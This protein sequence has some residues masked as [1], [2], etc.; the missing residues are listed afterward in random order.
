[1]RNS[2]SKRRKL[3]NFV[4]LC[5]TLVF[6]RYCIKSD[7]V[8]LERTRKCLPTP[9]P[10]DVVYTWV[11]G[12]DPDF[13]NQLKKQDKSHSNTAEDTSESRFQD[14]N[15]LL[16]SLR[17]IEQYAPWIRRVYIVTNGQIPN[18]INLTSVTMV[19]HK[20][21]FTEPSHLPNFNSLAI[22]T[23]LHEIPGLSENFIYFND[24]LSL[25]SPTCPEDFWMPETGYKSKFKLVSILA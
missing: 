9:F 13:I 6:F 11:N 23:H 4:L 22:E 18:W 14:F 2:L 12:S 19:N 1:M 20:S 3:S 7:K 5:L 21:I 10:I 25:M 8:E 16:Y 15:Q 17:S 24:D